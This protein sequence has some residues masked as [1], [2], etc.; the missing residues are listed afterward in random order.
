MRFQLRKYSFSDILYNKT[1][2][3]KRVS[4]KFKKSYQEKPNAGEKIKWCEHHSTSIF[5]IFFFFSK[6]V[7]EICS[8]GVLT[9]VY[10][11]D[12]HNFSI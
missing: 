12:F 4:L 2:S 6:N 10:T 5:F 8:S 9:I 1:G 11:G 3:Q 7:Q